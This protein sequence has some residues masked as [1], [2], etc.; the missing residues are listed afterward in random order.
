V[1]RFYVSIGLD[2]NGLKRLEFIKKHTDANT[3]SA[4]LR[5][6][7]YLLYEETVKALS[8]SPIKGEELI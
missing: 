3:K 7:L 8:E 4:I 2:E 6:G 5:R 1:E